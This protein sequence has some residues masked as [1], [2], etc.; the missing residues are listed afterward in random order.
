M[1]GRLHVSSQL[2]ERRERVKIAYLDLTHA[3]VAFGAAFLAGAINS[4]AGGGTL[5]SFPALIWLGLGSVTANA[6]S[7]VAIWPGTLGSAW[8]YRRELRDAEPRFRILIGRRLLQRGLRPGTDGGLPGNGIPAAAPGRR[9]DPHGDPPAAVAVAQAGR[10]LHPGRRDRCARPVPADRARPAQPDPRPAGRSPGAGT[11]A[12]APGDPDRVGSVRGAHARRRT[13]AYRCPWPRPDQD[14]CPFPWRS[15]GYS[16]RPVRAG[17][18]PGRAAERSLGGAA[19]AADGRP[20]LHRAAHRAAGAA[21]PARGQ[22]SASRPAAAFRGHGPGPGR[23]A[24]RAVGTPAADRRSR[25]RA[26][27]VRGRPGHPPAGAAPRLA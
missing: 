16:H 10:I 17:R 22:P 7:T 15:G 26:P 24:R 12:R 6:T 19:R 8:G 13:D 25:H 5:V 9:P 3:A 14:L 4:V 20:E 2:R 21:L 27:A 23:R 11:Q 1:A 18:R